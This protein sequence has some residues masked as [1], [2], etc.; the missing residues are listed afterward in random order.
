M[1]LVR[2]LGICRESWARLLN[3]YLL[4]QADFAERV[5]EIVGPSLAAGLD[6]LGDGVGEGT[7][8]A[9]STRTNL[10]LHLLRVSPPLPSSALLLSCP[11]LLLSPL[12]SLP[13]LSLAPRRAPPLA[14]RTKTPPS[15]PRHTPAPLSLPPRRCSPPRRPHISRQ[16]R[17]QSAG[18]EQHLPPRLQSPPPTR[19]LVR[20]AACPSS[21]PPPPPRW[22]WSW[23]SFR[24]CLPRRRWTLPRRRRRR[25]PTPW[26]TRLDLMGRRCRAHEHMAA[27]RT[28]R[29]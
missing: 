29:E 12:L 18:K 3:G 7:L 19:R 22:P 11:A 17:R 16:S 2:E 1:S 28:E 26:P 15:A 9:P 20:A 6:G 24:C 8:E 25:R 13:A 21:P 10:F 27:L 23:R 14:R 4:E 5:R